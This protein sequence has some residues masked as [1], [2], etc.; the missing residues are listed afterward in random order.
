LVRVLCPTVK[1]INATGSVAATT[2]VV[3]ATMRWIKIEWGLNREVELRII[4]VFRRDT[5]QIILVITL[6]LGR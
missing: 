1:I 5:V 2:N 3:V 6:K 4:S